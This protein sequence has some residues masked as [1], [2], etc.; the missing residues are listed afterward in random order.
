MNEISFI[1]SLCEVSLSANLHLFVR[2][3][4][5]SFLSEFILCLI[6]LHCSLVLYHIV[7][8]RYCLHL[9][10]TFLLHH[11]SH[12]R[13]PAGEAHGEDDGAS[14]FRRRVRQAGGAT[15]CHVGF[16][17]DVSPA[18]GM[19]ALC[20][21]VGCVICAVCYVLYTV[22]CVLCAMCCV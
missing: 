2:R 22:C 5:S 14:D 9:P 8:P 1:V 7:S 16:D 18:D 21:A 10:V 4:I 17:E 15:R 19:R 6:F 12:A 20:C 11:H 13:R 3:L